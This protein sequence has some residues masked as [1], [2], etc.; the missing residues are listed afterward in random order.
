MER[1]AWARAHMP[2]LRELEAELKEVIEKK[3]PRETQYRRRKR[4]PRIRRAMTEKD[5]EKR[6]W[7]PWWDWELDLKSHVLERMEDRHFTEVDLRRMMEHATGFRQARRTGRW[8]IE[9][10]HQDLR[11]EVVVQ[12]D[13][14]TELLG[15]ITA[16]EVKRKRK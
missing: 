2:L 10:K 4:S 5:Q 9:T 3:H 14:Y 11:W 6:D 1:V 8:I 12:P 13:A 15:V 7:P 16:Y